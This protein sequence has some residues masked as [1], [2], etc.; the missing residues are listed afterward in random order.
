[1]D[2]RHIEQILENHIQD[3]NI[4]N[5]RVHFDMFWDFS[6]NIDVT[7]FSL[8]NED[9]LLY[10]K[11]KEQINLEIK[12][13]FKVAGIEMAFPTQEVILKKEG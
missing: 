10:L 13:S 3:G 7:Y 6:L 11:Q 1:M 5:Y 4:S 2:S 8:I 9:Y 12:K